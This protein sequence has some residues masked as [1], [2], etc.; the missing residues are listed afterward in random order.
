MSVLLDTHV[1]VW[2]I[3]AS[4]SLPA[5]HRS[6]LENPPGPIFVS[7]VTP[8]EIALKVKMGK[9]PGAAALLPDIDGL[10]RRSG[11]V[12][13]PMSL[14]QAER[15]G[16]LARVHRDPFDRILAAQAL[17]LD[18]PLATVDAHLAQLGCKIV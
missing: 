6:L 14:S 5:S 15:A 1:F 11:L 7:A 16:S 10:V 12:G 18:I 8:L 2:W 13:L 3:T 17:D 4:P 9:W